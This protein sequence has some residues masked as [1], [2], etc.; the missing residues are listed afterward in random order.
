MRG[1]G[2]LFRL[3]CLVAGM[4][5]AAPG[6]AQ[7]TVDPTAL[8]VEAKALC[9][10]D[11][12]SDAC[13]LASDRSA[14]LMAN[15]VAEAGNTRD[16]GAFIDLVRPLLTDRSPQVRTAAA[17]AL[18]KFK[19]D[20]TDTPV[21]KSLLADPVSNVRAGAWAA[22]AL[23]A[24][25]AARL[26]K[27]RI[28]ERPE[29]TG[30]EPDPAPL[31]PSALG[32][33]LPDGAAFLWLAADERAKGQAQ[34]LLPT[35]P[36]ATLAT[37]APLT[38][39]PALS[40]AD[41]VEAD[42]ATGALVAGF[43]DPQIYGD[44]MVLVLDP[45]DDLP[46]RL[47]VVYRDLVFGQTGLAVIFGDARSLV[48]PK[49]DT[50]DITFAPDGT[51]DPEG[52]RAA[53]LAASG[54]KPDA[55]RDET[56]LFLSVIAAG[57]FGADGYLEVYPH[58]AY[59]TEAQA[60]LDGPRLILE[61]VSFTDAEDITVRFQNLPAGASASLQILS[62]AE[63]YAT[64]AG[65]FQPDA[66]SAT[67]VLQVA[68]LLSP[69]VHLLQAE[70][71]TADGPDSI[72][73]SQDFSIT[74]G[75]AELAL[76]K[77]EFSPG[78]P[79][80][81]RF[82]G[83]PGD[84]QDYVATAA[85]GAPN[86]SYVA[87]VY[88]DSQREGSTTLTAPTTPGAYE[89]RAFFREDETTLRASLPFTVAGTVAPQGTV[90]PTPG[91]PAPEARATLVLDKTRYA[92]GEMITVTFADMFGDGQD[93]VA[94]APAGS[95]N[96]IYL[97]YAYTKGEREGTATLPAPPTAGDYELRA[98]FREDEAILRASVAFTVE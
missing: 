64:M 72:F 84:A 96:G 81:I 44:P 78:E 92:P 16:R 91:D 57:G 33:A 94:T 75:M 53:L 7:D 20:E 85:A 83:M 51:T 65:Q 37:L 17:Y 95:S 88:T 22:A 89:L 21:L 38:P 31:D 63:D 32:F 35:A 74:P 62:V 4:A 70:V 77:T 69:G 59:A 79:M 23:S 58:G 54:I 46:L 71:S 40:V 14:A 90:T 76:E 26:V 73:L 49:V 13:T 9:A 12:E 41:L 67:T 47:A 18:A 56:E 10:A 5:S 86:T 28:P 43:L 25:P 11:A 2:L 50:P 80:A 15:M 1:P 93:Y 24:D 3:T 66:T 34:F 42:P 97:Q 6:F 8:I 61:D 52:N 39:R 68:G 60:I 98:F 30:Y 48:P 45:A 19:P 87:Y 36:E 29:S 27:R 55:P 82:S